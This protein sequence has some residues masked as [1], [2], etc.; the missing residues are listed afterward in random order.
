MNNL[1]KLKE[2]F[3]SVK[4]QTK[5]FSKEIS[6]ED[7]EG[8]ETVKERRYLAVSVPEEREFRNVFIAENDELETILSS[9]IEKYR[10]IKGYEGIWSSEL[11]RVECE[12]ES[13]NSLF[14]FSRALLRRLGKFFEKVEETKDE[15][16]ENILYE[17]PSPKAG[18]KI[19]IGASTLDFTILYNSQKEFISFSS[20]L[21]PRITIRIEGQELETHENATEFLVKLANSVLFQ[22][23]LATN[24][25][26]HLVMDR[27][28][29]RGIKERRSRQEKTDFQPPRYEYDKE[30]LALY[31]YAR[32]SMDMPLLQFLAFYQVIEFYFPLYSFTEAQQRIKN[33]LKN[34]LFNMNKDTDVAQII[35]AIKFSAKG[36]SIGDEKTQI[37]ATLLNI[38]DKES[39]LTFYNDSEE[40]K[41]F[42]DQQKKIKGLIRQKIN[43]SSY[44]NDVRVETA[45]RVYE[46][47]NRI[48]HSKEDD[49]VELILPYSTEIKNLKQDL[50]LIEFLAKKAIIAGGRPL[51]F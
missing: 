40:R 50:E 3:D 8:I 33:L 9:H 38:V 44:E 1:E 34:P 25:P 16:G 23:D 41:D 32:T 13:Q 36:K 26:L 10:F 31:W 6:I 11:K 24:I 35:N 19:F 51:V 42:F 47:R 5:F 49:E 27:Q 4:F 29:I 7:N 18:I 48:V 45:L 46:I 15:E 37:K 17:F 2:R 39:L 43:F 28:I 20:R 30:P 14:H 12:V 22:I 21:R